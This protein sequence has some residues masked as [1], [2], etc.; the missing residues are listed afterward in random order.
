MN[1]E[2]EIKERTQNRPVR[3]DNTTGLIIGA[4]FEFA[5]GDDRPEPLLKVKTVTGLEIWK[6][7]SELEFI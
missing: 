4:L 3:V 6:K 5:N 2:L 1:R 7:E